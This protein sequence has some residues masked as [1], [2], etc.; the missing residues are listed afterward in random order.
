MQYVTRAYFVNVSSRMCA[1]GPLAGLEKVTAQRN[2]CCRYFSNS[3]ADSC[4]T[5]KHDAE[6]KR[7]LL[8]IDGLGRAYL[9]YERKDELIK[10][11]HTEVPQAFAG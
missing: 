2:Q 1:K 3:L 4:L 10:L 6:A 9:E 7:F 11:M 5:V 8:D